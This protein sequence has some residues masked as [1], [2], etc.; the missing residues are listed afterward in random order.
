MNSLS[1]S[2]HHSPTVP[3]C[4]DLDGTLVATDT[5][6]E[7]IFLLLRKKT[8]LSFLL[9]LWLLR[10]RAYLKH[11]IAQHV[12][13][14]VATLPYR[15]NIL[16]FLKREQDRGRFIILATA[17]HQKIAYPIAKHLRIFAEVIASDA[18]TNVKGTVKRDILLQ[19]FGQFD[20]M[21][22]STADIPIFQAARY[23]FLVA[24]NRT[25]LKKIPCPPHRLFPIYPITLSTW[26]KL[27]RPH[28]WVKNVLIFL[29]LFLAHQF[30]DF[31]ALTNAFSAFLAF[32]MAA[33]AGYI[34]NDL[35]DLPA[36]RSHPTKKRRPFAAGNIPIAYGLPLFIL[37]VALSLSSSIYFLSLNFAGLIS[38]YLLLTMTYSFLLKSKMVLDVVVLAALYTFRIFA[39]GIAVS[40]G[41]SSWLLAFSMFMFMSLAFLKR[42]TELLQLNHRKF[43]KHRDYNIEDIEMI[44]SM[45]PTN[46]YLAVLVFALYIN[47]DQVGNYSSP[48]I[49]W[50]ICPPLLYWI[51]R[52][53]F[54]THRRKMLD[55]PVKFA[56][57][58]PTSWVTVIGIIIV[59]LLAKF[60]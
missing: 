50:M 45:G 6:W 12:K 41:I 10:G 47:S 38:S 60:L 53:W 56:L 48:F 16:E 13:L 28:Q 25:L 44:A 24:P 22:D 15:E 43:V 35:L 9:P 29:P 42:Y 17:A 27:L 32:S 39:G 26:L 3:L 30:Q 20:Y 7:S 52:I 57:A 23:A 8:L 55:D 51:T 37:L 49:L 33:S 36:D 11:R 34:L 1:P 2:P 46:G 54:L 59:V 18:T 40:V 58:D 4:V 14:N 21:G 31:Q 19:R 5:L